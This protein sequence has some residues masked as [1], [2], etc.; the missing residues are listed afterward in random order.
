[1]AA[2]A[3]ADCHGQYCHSQNEQFHVPSHTCERADML[4]R[5]PK[6]PKPGPGTVTV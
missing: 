3:S 1:L 6:R 4:T 2:G 5:M